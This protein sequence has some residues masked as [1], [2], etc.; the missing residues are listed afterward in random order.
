MASKNVEFKVGVI[1]LIGIVILAMSLYWLEGYKLERN[2]I[3]L[4]VRFDDVGTLAAGDKVT[5]SGVDRGKVGGL[6]LTEGGVEVNL[7]LRRDVKLRRDARITIKNMGVM[8]E[9]FVAIIPGTDSVEFDYSK[10]ITGHYDAGLPEVMGLL[11]DMITELRSLVV[12]FRRSVGSDSSLQK[13]NRT[14]DN[15]EAVSAS[16]VG[17]LERNEQKFD[18]TAENFLVASRDLNRLVS[19]NS[20]KIDSSMARVERMSGSLETIVGHLDTLAVSAREFADNINNPDGTLQ[21]LLEDRRLYDDLRATAANID[22]LVNDIRANPRKYIN[23][24]VEIF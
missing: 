21:L 13:F 6:Q 22:D 8:G 16:L 4:N 18:R 2:S 1:I 24:T 7:L 9:R 10:T 3:R 12:S 11:G 20:G 17:Y 15:L 23:L 19:Q 14:V 5:V